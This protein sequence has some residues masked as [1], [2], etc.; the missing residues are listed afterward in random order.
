M[1]CQRNKYLAIVEEMHFQ[2]A[3]K[4]IQSYYRR[5]LAQTEF[6]MDVSDVVV[7]QS[8]VRRFL[9]KNFY[10]KMKCA[11]VIQATW[12]RFLASEYYILTL[13]DVI[14]CQSIV[15]RWIGVTNYNYI[16]ARRE[17]AAISI[18]KVH[19][20]FIKRMKYQ[21]LV[22]DIVTIQSLVRRRIAT[23]ALS[24]LQQIQ[25][26]RK[27][28]QEVAA[29][30][31]QAAYHGFIAR[32][33]FIIVIGHVISLQSVVR[34]AIAKNK[35]HALRKCNNAA[36]K[37]RAAYMGF[38]TRMNYLITLDSII[39]CQCAIRAMYAKRQLNEARFMKWREENAA[40]T[41]IQCSYRR[42]AARFEYI[43]IVSSI[44][45]CQSVIRMLL[46]KVDLV[47]RR[48][49][50]CNK[51]YSAATLI[52]AAYLGFTARMNYIL[53]VA[54]I[55]TIQKYVRGH[56]ARTWVNELVL[57]KRTE[58]ITAAN[59]RK[60]QEYAAI[61]IQKVF[62]GFVAYEV[63]ILSLA[64]A[65]YIQANIR[66]YLAKLELIRLRKLRVTHQ[67]ASSIQSVWRSHKAQTN[68]ALVI[69][70][71]ISIQAI[72][73]RNL[74]ITKHQNGQALRASAAVIL[75][76]Y[77]RRCLVIGRLHRLCEVRALRGAVGLMNSEH[78]SCT[79]IQ[80]RWKNYLLQ[81]NIARRLCLENNAAIA[82]QKCFRGYRD[83]LQFVMMSFSVIQIQSV[84]RSYRAK[85]HLKRLK[86][87]R[88]VSERKR[89]SAAIVIQS[90][91][92]GYRDFVRF[93]LIQYF[94]IKIQSCARSYNARQLLKHHLKQDEDKKRKVLEK[95]AA[96]MIERFF[97]KIKAEIELE[98]ARLASKKAPE[99]KLRKIDKVTRR[100]WQ[101]S[102]PK[103]NVSSKS[104][105]VTT[106]APSQ[107]HPSSHSYLSANSVMS[108]GL[109]AHI[110]RGTSHG[111][112]RMP[113]YQSVTKNNT[114]S[115]HAEQRVIDHYPPHN[116]SMRHGAPSREQI[117]LIQS[118]GDEGLIAHHNAALYGGHDMTHAYPVRRDM[119]S[120]SPTREQAMTMQN[121]GHY[122]TNACTSEY[123]RVPSPFQPGYAPQNAISSETGAHGGHGMWAPSLS[124][125]GRHPSIHPPFCN[126]NI[127]QS[128]GHQMYHDANIQQS[129]SFSS[130]F[131]QD[132]MQNQYYSTSNNLV[133]T[134]LESQTRLSPVPQTNYLA[135][136]P[137]RSHHYLSLPPVANTYPGHQRYSQMQDR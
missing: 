21:T 55:V 50:Q 68:Y 116:N 65:I 99:Q 134:N 51:E 91:F 45:T 62:R 128:H 42:H 115:F 26:Y 136:V 17:T 40:A 49:V 76:S 52:K 60:S 125:N 58:H 39:T 13:S 69:Y 71:I 98:I 122:R 88:E 123:H 117:N 94:I 38:I 14:V 23:K 114:S 101:Q 35:L 59:L 107:F 3:A 97:I 15:R 54:D 8:T 89:D 127:P 9:A 24:M 64:N 129:N 11:I 20:G 19:R 29:T 104:S 63:A 105:D 28:E 36:T 46:A 87:E 120:A 96:L 110:M 43:I 77:V 44:I 90:S 34:S 31:I 78:A 121:S 41:K 85:L 81:R 30:K 130:A 2:L 73:R 12:R 133:A 124:Y 57:K 102:N 22:A 84:A 56:Q 75:Q 100:T 113:S 1:I 118:E 27:T 119:R 47:E 53:T 126:G 67:S 4:Q 74:V 6:L 37:I 18:Q 66:K 82:I 33:D 112:R 72:H 95:A 80:S 108:G 7:C 131:H 79:V 48:Q 16:L 111:R 86:Q 5:Y 70:G 92:R 61:T 32:I 93:V 103:R 25:W 137:N 109:D 106:V 132:Q 83:C 135:G 10:T